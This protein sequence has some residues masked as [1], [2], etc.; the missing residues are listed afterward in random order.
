MADLP[1]LLAV[2]AGAVAALNPC[3]FVLLPA[4]L[5]MLV[6]GEQERSRSE[7]VMRALTATFAMTT[8][9]TV[10][11]VTFGLVLAPVAG[12]LQ[13]HL[14]WFT[15]ALG[16]L[17]VATA[18]WLLS[19]R[20]LPGV[21][22]FARSGPALSWSML[23]M[24]GFGAAYALASLSCTVGPF[25]AIVVSAFRAGSVLSGLGLFAAYAAG[26]GLVVGVASLAVAFARHSIVHRLRQSAR[27]IPKVGGTVMLLAGAYVAY[28][29]WY[30]NAVLSGADPQD[31][32]VETAS[33]AQG[34]TADAV[35]RT[36]TLVLLAVLVAVVVT[37]LLIGVI[38]R[39]R[40]AA[41]VVNEGA[42]R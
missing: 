7:A 24:T 23:S 26:M 18:L 16:L 10:V 9:F 42:D 34:W 27:W 32:V 6:L 41:A 28:Y 30:E 29:G 11:F 39:R 35:Q 4:Y 22:L 40:R 2:S 13:Q 31:P 25:L 38:R 8:G 3:G 15:V 17:L 37:V 36:S 5:S 20:D 19:G 12:Q 21:R 1:L 14:P 33:R